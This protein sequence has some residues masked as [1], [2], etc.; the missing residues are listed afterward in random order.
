MVTCRNSFAVLSKTGMAVSF[1]SFCGAPTTG[2]APLSTY[3]AG[4]GTGVQ[5][6]FVGV[7][8]IPMD[9]ERVLRDQTVLV[10]N[11]RIVSMEAD[12]AAALP[13]DTKIVN[14][15]GLFLIPGLTDMHV[16][17]RSSDGQLYLDA[18]VTSV[19]NMWGF[20]PLSHIVQEYED[21]TSAGPTIYSL[22]SGLD[23][24]PAKWPQTQLIMDTADVGRVIDEQ[25]AQG[26]STLKMYQD[27]RVNI[28]EE[29]VRV[30]DARGLKYA[31]HVP[32]RVGLERVL[33]VGYSSIEHLSGYELF[34][35]GGGGFGGWAGID[36]SGIPGIAAASAAAGVWNCPTLA[37]ALDTFGA[38]PGSNASFAVNR[39]RMVKALHDAGAGLLVGTDAGIDRTVPGTSLHDELE[40]F[41]AAGLSPYAA[42]LGAT[43]HAADFLGEN[44][45]FGR[46]MVGLRADLVLLAGNPLEDITA[47]R[48]P[49]GVMSR[50][51]WRGRSGL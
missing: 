5:V 16:H 40:E 42:L 8:A 29:V 46:I 51:R 35:G 44:A 30:A 12:G 21:G 7:S 26:Y 4:I 36:P 50:G 45:E 23:G 48:D 47:V 22:S 41:V 10:S 6:A 24:T 17:V 20:S 18:G 39:R 19:R 11:G 1:L 3:D 2:L 15:E 32:H 33:E 25:V 34:L 14:A 28:F 31:G 49:V 9:T 43:G 13:P 37:I 38:P 27:L